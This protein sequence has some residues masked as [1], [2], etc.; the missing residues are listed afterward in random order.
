MVKADGYGHGAHGCAE[1]ALRGGASWLAVATAREAEQIGRRLHHIRLLT[2][3]AL[4]AP[5]WTWLSG[6]DRRSASGARDSGRC[7]A[8]GPGRQGP[9]ALVHVKHDSGMGRLGN[10]DPGE[11]LRLARACAADPDL[12]LA[13][14]W[15]HFATADETDGGFF[16]EQLERFDALAGRRARR[17]RRGDRCTPPTAPPP[18][19]SPRSHFD[20]VRCGVA[21]YGLDPFQGDPASARPRAGDGAALLRRRRQ[22]VQGRG[23]RRLRPHLG[24]APPTPGS[25]CSRS[26]TAT[27]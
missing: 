21:I 24:G 10:R 20:M 13:G 11:V 22:A 19:A 26:A 17:V 15:T 16:E 12:E 18:C 2:M 14:V 27:G 7:S 6:P 4:P 3:G 5:R 23:Q 25:A 1:A 9:A 8:R